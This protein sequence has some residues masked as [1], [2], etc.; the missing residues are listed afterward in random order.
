M[1]EITIK[2]RDYKINLT[3]DSFNRRTIQYYNSILAQFK[4]LGISND[5]VNITEERVTI[6]RAPAEVSWWINETHCNFSYNKMTKFVDN[7]L[8]VLKVVERHIDEVENGETSI[9]EFIET[10]KEKHDVSEERANAR[11]FFDLEDNHIDLDTVNKKYKL[12]AK[13]LHPDMPE[14]N[15]DKFKELNKH[16]KTLKRELE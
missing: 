13:T 16:H 1:P 5:D 2:N 6:K 3:K 8:V 10:F 14:G 7:L 4:R 9:E 11:K 12:L 15:I